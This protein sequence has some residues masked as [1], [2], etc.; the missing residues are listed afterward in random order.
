MIGQKTTPKLTVPGDECENKYKVQIQI[1]KQH[2]VIHFYS[3]NNFI[4][5]I[6]NA[7]NRLEINNHL[8]RDDLVLP[9]FK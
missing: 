3:N 6:K 9:V 5:M 4:V 1:N 8:D 2:C 7:R